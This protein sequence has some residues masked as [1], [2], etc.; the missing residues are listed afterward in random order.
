MLGPGDHSSF[1]DKT[2]TAV[3][4]AIQC[5]RRFIN[6]TRDSWTIYLSSALKDP[7]PVLQRISKSKATVLAC[8]APMVDNVGSALI[9]EPVLDSLSCVVPMDLLVSL[10]M[11]LLV[12]RVSSFR[13]RDGCRTPTSV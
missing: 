3:N 1:M 7:R 11:D 8:P 4:A 12:S 5:G 13:C 2:S 9:G 10:R 6:F